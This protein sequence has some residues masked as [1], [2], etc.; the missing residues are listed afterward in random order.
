MIVLDT[1]IW[2]WWINEDQIR[3]QLAWTA[4]IESA[5]PV[6]VSAIF[7]FAVAWLTHHGRIDLPCA[8]EAWFE[9][10]LDG[11]GITLLTITARIARIAVELP[12]HHRDPHKTD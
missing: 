6:G 3:L 11:S 10:A 12:E 5:E 1:H 2:L 7:C 9:K 8:E 4:R